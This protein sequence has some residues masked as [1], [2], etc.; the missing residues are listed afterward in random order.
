MP[1]IRQQRPETYAFYST[2]Y[3]DTKAMLHDSTRSNLIDEDDDSSENTNFRITV[4][5]DA[6]EIVYL[7][8][9]YYDPGRSGTMSVALEKIS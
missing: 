2:G 3:V 1:V 9:L 7:H 5:L 4:D 6:G 8:V